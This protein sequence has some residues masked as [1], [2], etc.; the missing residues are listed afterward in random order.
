MMTYIVPRSSWCNISVL[1]V[2]A[3]SEEKS[4]DT[5]GIFHEGLE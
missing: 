5:K 2:H 4:N 1:N 3:P